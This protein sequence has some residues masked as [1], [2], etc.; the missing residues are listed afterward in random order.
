[1]IIT[2]IKV[3]GT[4]GI[5]DAINNPAWMMSEKN[6]D[7]SSIVH[8]GEDRVLKRFT[9][10]LQGMKPGDVI[11]GWEVVDL[12]LTFLFQRMM[13]KGMPIPSWTMQPRSQWPIVDV[14][15]V[16]NL[17]GIDEEMETDLERVAE[18][19]G[20]DVSK[21]EDWVNIN[22]CWRTG[23]EAPVIK[24]CRSSIDITKQVFDRIRGYKPQSDVLESTS[25]SVSEFARV[26]PKEVK[27]T[28]SNSEV[29]EKDNRRA[30]SG[31][32]EDK[33]ESKIQL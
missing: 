19:M 14:K 4:C 18:S 26:K 29:S 28:V 16:F 6:G 25:D 2:G 21:I 20:F 30:E 22:E 32:Q 3:V 27:S 12:D 23:N 10:I 15:R 5:G 8:K 11:Y 31:T 33:V 7:E 1:M 13:I 9:K 17:H 24:Y